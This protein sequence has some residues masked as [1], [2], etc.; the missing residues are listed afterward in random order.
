M[1]L[2]A[3]GPTP[4]GDADVRGTATGNG[5]PGGSE[6]GVREGDIDPGGL[7]SVAAAPLCAA[8]RASAR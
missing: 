8:A 2:D 4:G 7:G 5:D 3:I 1:D 6:A